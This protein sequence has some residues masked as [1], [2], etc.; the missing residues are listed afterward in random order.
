MNN[1][2]YNLGQNFGETAERFGS[3]KAL[4][5]SDGSYVDYNFVEITSNRISNYLLS[6]GISRGDC[7]CIF[8]NKSPVALSAIIACL[9]IGAVYSNLDHTSPELRLLKM[10]DKCQPAII[11]SFFES[12]P[13]HHFNDYEI[14]DCFQPDFSDY[15]ASFS[16]ER[17]ACINSVCGGDPAYIMFTSGST[18][19]PKGAVM[20]HSNVLN[21]IRWGIDRYSVSENDVLTNVNPIYFDN[22]VFDFYISLF[23]GASLTPMMITNHSLPKDIV[24]N[25]DRAGAT[26]WFSVPSMIVYLL[27]TKA[28]N[29]NNLKN[30]RI[31]SFG[32]EG[33]PKP[34]LKQLYDLY[35]DRI[36]LI[37][38]YGPTECSCICSSYDI[39][40]RDFEDMFGYAPLGDIAPNFK[41]LIMN[42]NKE[43]A[44]GELC[45][46]G[47][48]VG[49]GYYND[50]ERTA[51]SF[52]RNPLNNRYN[53]IMYKTG[54]IVKKMNG[55]LHFVARKDNQIKFMGYRIELE[56][57]EAALSNLSYINECCV[58]YK[59][60]SEEYS[61]IEAYV[62]T[63]KIVS[64]EEII[65]GLKSIIP[66]YMLPKK[67]HFLEQL[68]KNQNGKID[69]IYLKETI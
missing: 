28:L 40:E 59:K 69:K 11:L 50:P 30:L 58:I 37:N 56:E 34:K 64:E 6:K 22:S 62:A 32:G 67:I 19:F 23:S 39:T 41:Y 13:A 36:K 2:Y 55:L 38:V 8:S 20:S 7:V 51:S 1:Y 21:L 44:E 25:V 24:N 9:K 35:S 33:F 46:L 26:I 61:I 49:L 45:L 17:P 48:Q 66:T 60:Y 42:D 68:P 10:L 16:A 65:N 27:T 52:V 18:G 29:E 57:I 5:Y 3:K 15:I 12:L 4:I 31:I 63:N 14:V 43:S 47:P 53:E 54:D